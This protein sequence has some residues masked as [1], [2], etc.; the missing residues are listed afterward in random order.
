M[1]EDPTVETG[2]PESSTD[3][4]SL[5]VRIVQVF[6]SPGTLFDRLKQRPAWLGALLTLIVVS[7]VVNALIPGELIRQ[8]VMEQLPS[9]AEPRQIETAMRMAGIFRFLG[10]VVF[11]PLLVAALAG[12]IQLIW[13]L[14]LGG[15]S[16]FKQALSVTAHT[17]FI[18][19]VGG[20]LTVP[21]MIA[22][23]DATVALSLHLLVPGLDDESYAF[24]FL[25]GL[26]FFSIWAA[27]VLG[28]G[29]SRLYPK[30]SAGSAVLVLL[31]LYVVFKAISAALSG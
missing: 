7:L 26:N 31:A 24:R 10:P 25:H 2:A 13:N 14:I 19:T 30:R 29:V 28:I 11:T 15:E 4:P 17:M 12:V 20:L 9:D 3:L 1:T 22:S 23:G 21:L 27:I 8:L 5:P 16:S 6:F 18:P